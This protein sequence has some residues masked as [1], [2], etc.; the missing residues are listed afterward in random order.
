MPLRLL[1]L[2]LFVL[3]VSLAPA[4]AADR[5]IEDFYGEYVGQSISGTDEGLNRRD[6]AVTIRP[7]ETGEGFV[8]GWTTIIPKEG[9]ETVRRQWSIAFQPAGRPHLFG[10][11]MQKDMFGNLQPLDPLKGE[12]YVWARIRGDTLSVYVMLVTKD[13][14][15]EMQAYHRTLTDGGM[16]L[17]FTRQREGTTLKVVEGTLTRK[18]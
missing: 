10:S 1:A 4:H 8:I 13:G 17:R 6:L 3:G 18:S 9:G 7:A 2:C 12:P 11:A 14:G 15:Y 5:P 16:H